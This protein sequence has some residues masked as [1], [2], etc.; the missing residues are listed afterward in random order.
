[1]KVG[2]R[3]LIRTQVLTQLS[4][5][6]HSIYNCSPVK[7]QINQ[8]LFVALSPQI[9]KEAGGGGGGDMIL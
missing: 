4:E 5:S 7:A 8:A 6:S 2:I 1:M 3:L 9:D